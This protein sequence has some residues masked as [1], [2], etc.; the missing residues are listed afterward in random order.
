MPNNLILVGGGGHCQS[1]IDV[2]EA[3]GTRKIAG[4]LD[5]AH[6]VGKRV[7]NYKITGSEAQIPSLVKEHCFLITVGQIQTSEPR[8]R[9]FQLIR[10]AGGI[11]PTIVSPH[12]H[13]SPYAT[14][15]EGSVVMHQALVNAGASV[16][17]NS[18]IN[19]QALIEHGTRIGSHCHVATGAIIN[20]NCQIDDHT[21]VGSRAV[22][23][24]GVKISE[25]VIVGAGAVVTQSLTESGVYVGIPAR[26][27]RSVD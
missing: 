26:K 7:L 17:I 12:A 8:A 21:F 15:G 24:Q 4:I 6:K 25:R 20:G 10:Q 16:G 19:S 1:V 13:V 27:I 23:L 11:F 14:L 3:E 9:L 5:V 18:I 22:I 2:I